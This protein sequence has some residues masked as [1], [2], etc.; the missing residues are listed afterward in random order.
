MSQQKPTKWNWNSRRLKAAKLLATTTMTHGDIAKE[1]GVRRD[2]VSWW[3]LFPEFKDKVNEFV[4]LDE[5]ATKAGILKKAL[6]TLDAKSDKAADDK[7]TELDY[8]KFVSE[9][10]GHT[11]HDVDVTINNAVAVINSPEIVEQANE[12]SRRLSKK[13]IEQESADGR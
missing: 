10:Q 5:R 1:C 9:L 7:N 4:L 12:L 13:I 2:T 3:N 6:K 11:K 8:L